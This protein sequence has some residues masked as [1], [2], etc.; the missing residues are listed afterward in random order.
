MFEKQLP[1]DN[2]VGRCSPR[3]G[4]RDPEAMGGRQDIRSRRQARGV[5]A[6]CVYFR[7]ARADN[8]LV[9]SNLGTRNLV[10]NREILI[11]VAKTPFLLV[12]PRYLRCSKTSYPNTTTAHEFL[13]R[14]RLK[15][16]F[17]YLTLNPTVTY[18]FPPGTAPKVLLDLPQPYRNP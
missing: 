5:S 17:I 9:F 13:P 1:I 18:N 10:S 7:S 11:I 12:A 2:C 6:W 14:N 15:Y 16:L 8:W 4:G 3:E